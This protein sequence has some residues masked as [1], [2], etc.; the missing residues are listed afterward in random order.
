[1]QMAKLCRH[2]WSAQQILELYRVSVRTDRELG[3]L[4]DVLRV[5]QLPRPAPTHED[6]AAHPGLRARDQSVAG[7]APRDRW[8]AF[9]SPFPS[10]SP[11]PF[12]SLHFTSLDWLIP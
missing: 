11:L 12:P 5:L 8:H 9:T 2:H 7:R 6:A 1:M 3:A 4:P 10:L